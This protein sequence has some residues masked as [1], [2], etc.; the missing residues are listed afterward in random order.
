M[1]ICTYSPVK[2]WDEKGI[3]ARFST[4]FKQVCYL[5]S[6]VSR[7]VYADNAAALL[8]GL[9]VG[10]TYNTASGDLKVVV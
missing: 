5:S 1:N 2:I 4:L 8:G 6:K 7:G 9:H 3:N 10:D